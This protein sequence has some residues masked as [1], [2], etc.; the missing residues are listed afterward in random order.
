MMPPKWSS[1]HR[2]KTEHFG[3]N[4]GNGF[5]WFA[6]TA[7]YIRDKLPEAFLRKW[8]KAEMELVSS[9]GDLRFSF[10]GYVLFTPHC[11]KYTYKMLRIWIRRPLQGYRLLPKVIISL[12]IGRLIQ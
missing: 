8:R 6:V 1:S 4:K 3:R 10:S 12:G 5:A 2:Y 11:R 9:S 7:A